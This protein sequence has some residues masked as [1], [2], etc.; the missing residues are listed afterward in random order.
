MACPKAKPQ[1]RW[2]GEVSGGAGLARAKRV[3]WT[4]PRENDPPDRFLI[5]VDQPRTPEHTCEGR[6]VNAAGPFRYDAAARRLRAK[7]TA[8]EPPGP[9]GCDHRRAR[10]GGAVRARSD[11]LWANL[12][13]EVGTYLG[14]RRA[15]DQAS[16]GKFPAVDGFS[17]DK[18]LSVKFYSYE[19]HKQA[20]RPFSIPVNSIHL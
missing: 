18:S 7:R 11:L 5:L 19:M 9:L 1:D 12:T 2:F 20:G 15:I 10:P 17:T 6:A 4:P 8:P 14:F 13:G 16:H 3:R